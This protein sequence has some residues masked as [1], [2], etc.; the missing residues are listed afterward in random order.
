MPIKYIMTRRNL[1]HYLLIWTLITSLV[2][3][4]L[5]FSLTGCRSNNH[6][7]PVSVTDYRRHS[8]RNYGRIDVSKYA[9][10]QG[11]KEVFEQMQQ[12]FG[13]FDY[14][15]IIKDYSP[16]IR[17]G[18]YQSGFCSIQHLNIAGATI[19]I[20]IFFRVDQPQPS[21]NMEVFI[22]GQLEPTFGLVNPYYIAENT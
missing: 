12:R 10:E 11:L 18:L 2:V 15:P 19:D 3:P 6:P 9:L 1:N 13:P 16:L 5:L 17:Q 22:D 7:V 20:D 4:G 14:E 21:M 8:A